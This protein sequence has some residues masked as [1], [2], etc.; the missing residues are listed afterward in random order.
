MVSTKNRIKS[1]F[2]KKLLSMKV[3]DIILIDH[4]GN[5]CK[6]VAQS[7]ML[8]HYLYQ[9]REKGFGRWSLLGHDN[10]NGTKIAKI[11]RRE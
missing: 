3:G 9:L 7:C 2:K 10:S 1:P 6:G 5:Y 4:T 8:A 11:L